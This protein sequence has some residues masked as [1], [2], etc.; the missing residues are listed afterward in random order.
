MSLIRRWSR[1][2]WGAG[3]LGLA[4]L[5]PLVS[6]CGQPAA[7]KPPVVVAAA[8][9]RAKESLRA[10]ATAIASET[11]VAVA[12]ATAAARD[13]AIVKMEQHRLHAY[14]T[15]TAVTIVRAH[16]HVSAHR[17]AV[18]VATQTKRAAI[19]QARAQKTAQAF[20]AMQ[21]KQLSYARSLQ[22][23]VS[24]YCWPGVK[25]LANVVT[26]GTTALQTGGPVSAAAMARLRTASKDFTYC[27]QQGNRVV[28]S[29]SSRS[30]RNHFETAV[31]DFALAVNRVSFGLKF[32]DAA[33]L[34]RGANVLW[35]GNNTLQLAISALGQSS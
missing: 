27:R 25:A 3:I 2:R 18:A 28:F 26:R 6:S 22:A 16:Q 4:A 34:Q 29:L 19:K 14:A 17:T 23:T 33:S 31:N 9:S 15:A 20:Q 11:S 8:P 21:Q 12:N 1:R 5:A 24:A 32:R 7:V 10:Q 30:V 35:Q 13:Q